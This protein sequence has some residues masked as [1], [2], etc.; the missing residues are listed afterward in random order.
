[1]TSLAAQRDRAAEVASSVGRAVLRKEDPPL[2][3][4]TAR[5][6]DDLHGSDAL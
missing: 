4:G 3:R 1:V 5:F 2:L 6:V